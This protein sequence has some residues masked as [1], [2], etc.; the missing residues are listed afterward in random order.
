M[1]IRRDIERNSSDLGWAAIATKL[2]SFCKFAIEGNPPARRLIL[3]PRLFRGL[4]FLLLSLP[5]PHSTPN[6]RVRTPFD[7]LKE[8]KEISEGAAAHR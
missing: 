2:G 3:A 6:G 8:I 1:L 4:A 7:F 5:Q